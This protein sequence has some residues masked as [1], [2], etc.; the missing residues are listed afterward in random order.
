VAFFAAPLWAKALIAIAVVGTMVWRFV[1]RRRSRKAYRR[2]LAAFR[3][4]PAMTPIAFEQHCADYLG[5]H[6][7]KAHT[8]KA[9]GDQGVDVIAENVGIRVVIQCKKQAR[10]V[11]NSAVQ[12]AYSAQRFAGAHH[13]AVVSNCTFTRAA[14]E[15][16]SA[17]GVLLLHFT[18][19]SEADRL[20]GK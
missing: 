9:S 14:Y 19:L 5:L 8:T 3:W 20:F 2:A 11:G 7:W 16:A 15:L 6:G 1:V 13:A 17:T 12:E 10:P 18:E 4:D